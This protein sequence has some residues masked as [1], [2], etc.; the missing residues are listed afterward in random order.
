MI[1]KFKTHK[2]LKDLWSFLGLENPLRSFIPDLAHITTKTMQLLNK[3]TALLWLDEH[4]EAFFLAKK[5][6]IEKT[7]ATPFNPS[8]KTI[9]QTD[10]SCRNRICSCWRCRGKQI[11]PN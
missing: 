9:V 7:T 10:A 3:G 4:K 1:S 2:N 5:T 11:Q 8:K 6:L